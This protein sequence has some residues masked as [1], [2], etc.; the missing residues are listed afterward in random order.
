MNPLQADADALARSSN[1]LD[2]A[3]AR[4]AEVV[5]AYHTTERSKFAR[6]RNVVRAIRSFVTS[7]PALPASI[8]VGPRGLTH[9]SIAT[10]RA[11][12][13]VA[14]P[15]PARSPY[16]RW[17]DRYAMRDADVA[18]VRATAK[19]LPYRP[20]ISILMA[21]YNS[22]DA[23]L[24]QAIDSVRAQAYAEWELCIADDASTNARVRKT[25]DAYAASDARIRVV[26]RTTN[27]HI[28]EASNSALAIASGEFVGFLDHDDLLT[29]DALF[30]V[31]LR[32]NEHHDADMI[33]SDEDKIDDAGNFS[34]PHFKPD[35]APDSFLSRMYTCHFGVYRRELAVA[36]GGLRVGYEGSQDH[37]FVLRLTERTDRIH[38]IPRVLYHWRIHPASTSAAAEAKPYAAVAGQRAV[39]DA[40]ERRGE[41]GVV[42]RSEI[43][44]IYIT[45]YAIRDAG[46]VSV[47][48]PTRDHGEDVDRCLSSIF[49]NDTYPNFEILLV[50]NGSKDRTSLEIFARWEGRE[51]RV[52]V[53][54]YDKPFNFSAIN[55]YAV[56]H[57]LGKY[58]LFLNNDTEVISSDW[59]QA[60]V[61]Q[62]QRPSIGVVGGLLLYPDDTIQHAGVVIGLGGVAGHSQNGLHRNDP[63]YFGS[64]RAIN[65][66]SALTAA[67]VMIRRSVFDEVGGFD[68]RLAVAFNDVDLSLKIARAG[69]RNVYLPH[70]MLYHYESKSRGA[71][72]TP[73]MKARFA[74]EVALMENRWATR[75][76][77]DPCYSPHLSLDAPGYAIRI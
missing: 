59:M 30:E 58:L 9:A 13:T 2:V 35:W 27:G 11:L 65:N 4:L 56:E 62:A 17:L 48:V 44:G 20:V 23:Y 47:I 53:V 18:R 16:E 29:P 36:I 77:P 14:L 49:S 24:R 22:P 66:F 34:E 45:R 38:H 72:T 63:G 37:D 5:E 3:R 67:C 12:Q 51:S 74:R 50:D 52:H 76:S 69:Y 68:E 1:E 42:E 46:L 25:L 8:A 15:H 75:T 41:P 40:I 60:M 10:A 32:L 28:S 55:N 70:V 31:A 39:Q 33:Y 71:E 7:G 26:K 57:S 43:P 6:L 21:T 54:R 61:E 64:V 73:E 19:L